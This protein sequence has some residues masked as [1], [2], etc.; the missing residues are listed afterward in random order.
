M[1]FSPV[2]S[3]TSVFSCFYFLLKIIIVKI[4]LLQSIVILLLTFQTLLT[5]LFKMGDKIE[6]LSSV[7]NEIKDMLI[8]VDKSFRKKYNLEPDFYVRVPGRVNLIGEHIDYCGYSVCP[9]A[10]KQCIVAAVKSRSDTNLT[11]SNHESA[12][13]PDYSGKID[14][15][16]Y[17]LIF[18]PIV[19]NVEFFKC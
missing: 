13:Y 2:S 12:K 6:L 14:N 5:A 7:D 1:S 19:T 18:R 16:E 15:L 8:T 17:V 4:S 9:M 11:L 10:I 3:L